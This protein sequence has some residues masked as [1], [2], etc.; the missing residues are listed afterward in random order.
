MARKIYRDF[1]KSRFTG[2]CRFARHGTTFSIHLP[3]SDFTMSS[4]PLM[5][6]MPILHSNHAFKVHFDEDFSFREIRAVLDWLLERQAFT[7]AVQ[8][9]QQDYTIELDLGCFQ[10]WVHEL[11]V[12]LRRI[13]EG[14]FPSPL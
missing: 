7:E 2:R 3:A 8:L 4:E 11:D 9:Q 14:D 6:S 12:V 10:V 5:E 13:V 1:Q